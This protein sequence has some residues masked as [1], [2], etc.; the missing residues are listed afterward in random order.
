ML[1][2]NASLLSLILDGFNSQHEQAT[3]MEGKLD[4]FLDNKIT[5][6]LIPIKRQKLLNLATKD[7]P[8]SI[9][10]RLQSQSFSFTIF[11]SFV[12]STK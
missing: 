11:V 3:R 10:P 2:L 9:D 12:S 5:F 7:T 8:I 1:N 4:N 6:E